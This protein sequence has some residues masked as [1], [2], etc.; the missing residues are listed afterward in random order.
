[1]A[2]DSGTSMSCSPSRIFL[3]DVS[4]TPILP[5]KSLREMDFVERVLPKTVPGCGGGVD[6]IINITHS[7]FYW[8][9]R[10]ETLLLLSKATFVVQFHINLLT[11]VQYS[12]FSAMTRVGAGDQFLIT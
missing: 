5:A 9:L 11:H 10:N 3:R 8:I 7:M 6:L 4:S 2:A 12:F 1:M